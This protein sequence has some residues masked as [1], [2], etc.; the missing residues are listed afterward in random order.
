[1]Q[2]KPIKLISLDNQTQNTNNNKNKNITASSTDTYNKLK[3]Y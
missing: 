3:F 1:M 2:M